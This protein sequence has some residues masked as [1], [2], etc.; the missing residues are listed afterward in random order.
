MTGPSAH[1]PLA[2]SAAHRWMRCPGSVH[3]VGALPEQE[4]TAA[5]HEGTAAHA[6]AQTILT[7][8][9]IGDQAAAEGMRRGWHTTHD[10]CGHGCRW[11]DLADLVAPYVTA[12]TERLHEWAQDGWHTD[13]HLERRVSLDCQIWGTADAII[14][15]DGLDAWGDTVTCVD[16]LDLK[17]GRQPVDPTS[18]QLR[19]YAAAA[20][21]EWEADSVSTCIVQPCLSG[22]PQWG[23]TM[24]RDEVLTWVGRVEAM[25]YLAAMDGAPRI[26][27]EEQCRWCPALAVCPEA[28]DRVLAHMAPA[29]TI[30]LVEAASGDRL[31]AL[32][33][34][35]EEAARWADAVRARARQEATEGRLP[36]WRIAPGRATRRMTMEAAQAAADAAGV[37]LDWVTE[38]VPLGI[39]AIRRELGREAADAARPLM[40]ER[41]GP[42]KLVR[43]EDS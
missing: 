36:G 5:M 1:A 42:D 2:P 32:T 11:S 17:C 13:L 40:E 35:A 15:A 24:S 10:E 12:V 29:P 31:S 21:I 20:L 18:E 37:G 25:A 28:R 39:T 26:P 14:V 9:A 34:A 38:Q 22:R 4:E 8:Q 16:V 3:L 33:Q 7:E 6:V 27:G 19:I 23:V 41:T 30:D 43:E